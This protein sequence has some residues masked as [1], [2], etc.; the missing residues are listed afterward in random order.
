MARIEI[1]VTMDKIITYTR[2][3]YGYGYED[4]YIY[5]MQAEDGKT[6]VWKTTT[7]LTLE[8]EDPKGW[9]I[10]TNGKAYRYDKINDGDKIRI[11]ATEKG[12]T[13]Y[14]GQPQTEVSRV[15]VLERIFAAE[16][17]EEKQARLKAEAEARKQAQL[18]S[19]SEGDFVW[20]MPYRQ[21]KEHYSDC[22]TVEG[23]FERRMGHAPTIAVI[24]RAGRLKPSGVRGE[25]Y[26]GYE[27][28]NTEGEKVVYRAVSEDNATKRVNK[29]FPESNWECT[30][31]YQY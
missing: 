2:P 13:E 4:A 22:E 26:H 21:F 19:I 14:N 25:H 27:F 1:T 30:K 10:K 18:D 8:V 12:E 20:R 11:K 5:I 28:T 31:I 23:S 9:V 24:I 15:V 16:T 29:E 17:W 6:Y 3:A 7:F